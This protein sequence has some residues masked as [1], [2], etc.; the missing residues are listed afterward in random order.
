M[1]ILKG[2]V[3]APLIEIIG[4]QVYL[5][6]FGKEIAM[7]TQKVLEEMKIMKYKTSAFQGILSGKLKISVV[8]TGKYVIP[9]FLTD[10]LH[11]NTGVELELDV[12]NR[13]QFCKT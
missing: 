10:F 1:V 4:K 6:D 7:Q 12:T 3:T 13:V 8:S 2:K 5:T 9:Y 11:Q